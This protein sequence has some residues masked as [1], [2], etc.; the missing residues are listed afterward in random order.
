MFIHP[1]KVPV[2]LRPSGN[3]WIIKPLLLVASSDTVYISE[4]MAKEYELIVS[5]AFLPV[6]LLNP[7]YLSSREQYSRWAIKTLP[8]HH[9]TVFFV[10]YHKISIV[11]K[12][13]NSRD[14]SS[15]DVG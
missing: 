1:G 12:H 6:I 4:A 11:K 8:N 2:N 3:C 9:G 13:C 10:S 15:H 14:R 7:R 5:V